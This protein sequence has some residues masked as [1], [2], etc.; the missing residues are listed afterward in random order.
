MGASRKYHRAARQGR[1]IGGTIRM[2]PLAAPRFT[3]DRFGVSGWVCGSRTRTR[4]RTILGAHTPTSPKTPAH[5]HILGFPKKGA[6]ISGT[7]SGTV[8]E[9]PAHFEGE[10]PSRQLSYS[11]PRHGVQ[12]EIGM[13][14]GCMNFSAGLYPAEPLGGTVEMRPG[15]AAFRCRP[16]TQ[17][18]SSLGPLR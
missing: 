7:N 10:H 18:A 4:R 6:K 9:A 16:R 5:R 12:G 13:A 15:L 14:R 8:P 2:R 11:P 1:R 17:A 3:S